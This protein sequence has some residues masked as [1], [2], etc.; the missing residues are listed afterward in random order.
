MN[1]PFNKRYFYPVV[2][3][4]VLVFGAVAVQLSQTGVLKSLQQRMEW[5]AYNVRLN[6]TLPEQT[7]LDPRIV[8][9]DIDEMSLKEEGRWPWSRDK[10]SK[11][12]DQ[13]FKNNVSVVAF[14]MLFA[15]PEENPA[16]RVLEKLSAADK[17]NA[18]PILR[19]IM[20]KLDADTKLAAQLTG[21]NVVL[22]YTFTNGQHEPVGQLPQPLPD[23]DNIVSQNTLIPHMPSYNANLPR[24]QQA[25][26]YGGFFD[27][28]VDEDGILRRSP[29]LKR[30]GDKLYA[31]LGLEVARASYGGTAITVRTV[32][33]GDA[34][35]VESVG[36]GGYDIPTDAE[37][38]VIIPYRGP[39]P[40]FT[41]L[42]ATDVLH[43]RVTQ[44]I[45]DNTIVFIGTTAPGLFD[46]R[47]TPMQEVYPGVEVHANIVSGILDQHFPVH[48]DWM[49]AADLMVLLILGIVLTLL[50]PSLSPLRALTLSVA[51]GA[52]LVAVNV[53]LWS[54]QGLVM[55][56][57]TPVILLFLLTLL[58]MAY[59]FLNESRGRILLKGKFGQY[60]PPELV[61][62]MSRNSGENFGFEGDSREMTVLFSDVRNFTTI[63]ESLSA[64]D[65]KKLLNEFFTPMTRVIFDRRG[66]ID[67]YVGDMIMAF[68]GAPMRDEHHARHALDAAL[69]I[70]A[71]VEEL[72]PIFKA[73]GLPEVNV[74]IGINTGMVNVGDMGSEFRRAYTVIG[75]TVNLASRLESLTKFYGVKLLVGENTRK[76]QDHILF[77]HLDVVRVK[78]KTDAV[79]IFEPVCYRE[80]A[81]AELLAEVEQYQ[82]A[83]GLYFTRQWSDAKGL[84]LR[85]Q[86][87]NPN[88]LVYAIYLDRIEKLRDQNIEP[89]WDGVFLRVNRRV[90]NF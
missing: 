45:L 68:W 82:E 50:L 26:R 28:E 14:D 61:E 4:L 13:L 38:R 40:S 65:L 51:L 86:Q 83:L 5:M 29:L 56:I 37:G 7:E 67:K 72:K 47:A 88:L 73:N 87:Q 9:V 80:Q 76:G 17:Q 10:L 52:T 60:V 55:N 66:T 77:R 84:F 79:N 90:N 85:L 35:A 36:L 19:E 24:L 41:Y 2:A 71:K 64:N 25:A 54:D 75:D 23:A 39:Y 43:G 32:L 18:E 63:S 16:Q 34:L 53:W 15:E 12:T 1:M 42:S 69:N 11:L 8:I 81:S 33:V 20:P 30:Y 89:D 62:E 31:A 49:E 74:G 58:N 6:A 22:G 3:G 48:P 21:R 70:L 78:G 27:A 46:M 57:A 59:G 44:S